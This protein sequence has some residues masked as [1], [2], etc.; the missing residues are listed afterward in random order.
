MY[1]TTVEMSKKNLISHIGNFAANFS[2]Y[3]PLLKEVREEY[4]FMEDLHRFSA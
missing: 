2:L 4:S 1:S 3:F